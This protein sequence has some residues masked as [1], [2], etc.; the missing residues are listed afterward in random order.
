M[1][2]F[3]FPSQSAILFALARGDK[4]LYSIPILVLTFADAVA[5]VLGERY[6]TVAYEGIGGTKSLEGSVAFFTVAF[7]SRACSFAAVH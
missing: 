5:A 1:G 7:F 6:G 2:S 4:L 3:T